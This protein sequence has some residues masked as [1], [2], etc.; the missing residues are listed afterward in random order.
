[1]RLCGKLLNSSPGYINSVVVAEEHDDGAMEGG[2]SCRD[3]SEP[4]RTH[5]SRHSHF[6]LPRE[7]LTA[8]V[9]RDIGNRRRGH[10]RRRRRIVVPRHGLHSLSQARQ[11]VSP[12][13]RFTRVPVLERAADE[14]LSCCQLADNRWGCQTDSRCNS[15][16]FSWQTCFSHSGPNAVTQTLRGTAGF[17]TVLIHFNSF[18]NERNSKFSSNTPQTL[19]L[20][21]VLHQNDAKDSK[22]TSW[23]MLLLRCKKKEKIFW[24][25]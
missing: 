6:H 14:R 1:M 23:P 24:N 9:W 13:P 21:S 12:S 16:W 22:S 10:T 2:Q 7:S 18:S 5:D 19:R 4:S 25:D 17:T 11:E 20:S 8:D 15:L 3:V